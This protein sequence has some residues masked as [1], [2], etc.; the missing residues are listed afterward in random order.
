MFS[1]VLSATFLIVTAIFSKEIQ[2]SNIH[3]EKQAAY[4]K[5]QQM[6]MERNNIF[7]KQLGEYYDYHQA[8]NK[9]ETE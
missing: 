3:R 8:N 5:E 6:C 2:H 4:Y 1:G 9:N 7:R